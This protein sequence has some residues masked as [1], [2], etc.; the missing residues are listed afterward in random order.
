MRRNT[1]KTQQLMQPPAWSG[2]HAFPPGL[3]E[4]RGVPAAGSPLTT[5]PGRACSDSSCARAGRLFRAE[6]LLPQG[7][8][9]MLTRTASNPER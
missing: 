7:P 3:S 8:F 2:A 4:P 5:S 6:E 1:P 9:E